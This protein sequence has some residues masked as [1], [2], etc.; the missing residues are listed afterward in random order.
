[1]TLDPR[2]KARRFEGSGRPPRAGRS[3][4]EGPNLGIAIMRDTTPCQAASRG[5]AGMIV[6]GAVLDINGPTERRLGTQR[7]TRHRTASW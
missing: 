6:D 5:T 1:M 7:D 2:T 4:L 3:R